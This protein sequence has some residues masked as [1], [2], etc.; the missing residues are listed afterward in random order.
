MYPARMNG[1]IERRPLELVASEMRRWAVY[2]IG[3]DGSNKERTPVLGS[4]EKE[5]GTSKGLDSTS[6]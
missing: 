4:L 2:K 5:A 3:G 1:M 6:R